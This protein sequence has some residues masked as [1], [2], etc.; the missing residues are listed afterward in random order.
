MPKHLLEMEHEAALPQIVN[1][2][3][4]ALMPNSEI[5][6]IFSPSLVAMRILRVIDSA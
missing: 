2:E 1:G 3:C 5:C 4:V 6:R